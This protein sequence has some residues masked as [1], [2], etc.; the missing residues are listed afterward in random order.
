MILPRRKLLH[1]AAAVAALPLLSRIA[2]ADD[3]YPSRPVHLIV[4]FTP[5]AAADVVGR[6][7]SQA[8]GPIL[9]QQ[10]VVENKPG[11]GSSIAAEY[12]AH[13]AKDGYTVFL[14]TLSIITN[15]II[16][17]NAAL[18]LTR[19]F[20]PVAL[21][22]DAPIILV[23]NPARNIHSVK[24]LVALCK[25]HP[26]RALD[27]NVIGSMPHFASELFAQAAGVKLTQVPYQGSP[28]AVEDV[29]AD[30]TLMTFSP[31]ST[32]VGLIA[33]GKLLALATTTGKRAG[34]LPDVPTMA[35]AGLPAV[36]TSLWF[37]L[38]VPAGTPRPIVDKLAAAAQKAMHTP[39]AMAALSK[40][41]DDPLDAGPDAFKTFM[42]SEIARWTKV[43]QIAGMV[44]S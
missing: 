21:I 8:A 9:G 41:G 20:E 44:K 37:G 35:E 33:A 16:N 42:K 30:R 31:V 26:D 23:V 17:P 3:A 25:A 10:V 18:D 27:S 12:A 19:D 40:Q 28:Q 2:I 14:G 32:V 22:Q 1:S 13:S 15:Q 4:G 5:G 29:V 6:V 43:A 36:N 39:S 24:E 38:F 7:F 11:A 34:A